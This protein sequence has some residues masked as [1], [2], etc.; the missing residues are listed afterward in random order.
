MIRLAL[1]IVVTLSV[2]AWAQQQGELCVNGSQAADLASRPAEAVQALRERCRPG[3]VIL[4]GPQQTGLVAMACDF[5]RAIAVT[6]G[7][8]ICVF[9]GGRGASR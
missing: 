9:M 8:V 6:G 3:D 2:P 1:L 5:N 4:I 7:R